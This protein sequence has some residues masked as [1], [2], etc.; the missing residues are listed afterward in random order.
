MHLVRFGVEQMASINFTHLSFTH[1]QSVGFI[2]RP[3]MELSDRI[4][5]TN[6]DWDPIHLKQMVSAD[7]YEFREFSQS[8]IAD[9]ELVKEAEKTEW[10][11]P[12]VED[13]SIDNVLYKVVQEIENE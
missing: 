9:K 13:I 5:V 4:F 3:I 12:L 8:N 7:F 1:W 6:F 10:Y 2:T 11:C